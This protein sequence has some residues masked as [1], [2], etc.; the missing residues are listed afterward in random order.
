ML[1]VRLFIQSVD[2]P[3][4]MDDMLHRHVRQAGLRGRDQKVAPLDLSNKQPSSK[5]NRCRDRHGFSNKLRADDFLI[6]H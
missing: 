1:H 6:F 4:F 2:E 3:F 5:G